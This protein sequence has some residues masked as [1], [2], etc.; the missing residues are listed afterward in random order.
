MSA[1]SPQELRAALAALLAARAGVAPSFVA[2]RAEAARGD[3]GLA[4]AV[5]QALVGGGAFI[6]EDPGARRVRLEEL[7][8]LPPLQELEDALDRRR[9]RPL[10]IEQRLRLA[11]LYALIQRDEKGAACYRELLGASALP[12]PMAI[13]VAEAAGRAGASALALAG[14]DRV[15]ETILT[16]D[17]TGEQVAGADLMREDPLG[18]GAL[19]ERARDIALTI[20]HAPRAVALARA[21]TALYERLGRRQEARESLAG[22]ARALRAAGRGKRARQVAERWRELA[23]DDGA[24]VSQARALAWLAGEAEADGAVRGAADLLGKAEAL[25]VAAGDPAGALD[26][27]RRRGAL[28]E[29]A[30]ALAEAGAALGRALALTEEAG[31]WPGADAAAHARAADD[32][33]LSLARLDLVG[34]RPGR[35]LAAAGEVRAARLADGDAAGAAA[36][37]A[38]VAEA[39]VLAGDLPGAMEVVGEVAP[40][41]AEHDLPAAR[42]RAAR[43]RA[44][45]AALDGR[46]GDA[47]LLLHDAAGDLRRAGDEAEAALCVLRRAEVLAAAGDLDGCR[48]ELDHALALAGGLPPRLELRLELL[49]ALLA[50]AEEADLLL[51]EVAERAPDEGDPW[52]RAAVAGA[53]ARRGERDGLEAAA[54]EVRA[55]RDDLPPTLRAGFARSPLVR[56]LGEAGVERVV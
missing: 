35:A 24:E 32:L 4:E 13:E 16:R 36:A 8:A 34:G 25:L 20:G 38:V 9:A 53:R 18:A 15:A 42:G 31:G 2:A 47:A 46:P 26:H 56:L 37:A 29:R 6:V 33:R 28:L 7:D 14:I 12:V 10:T 50:P 23:E 27:A 22:Q 52:V 44:E 49:R 54:A 39:L 43:A 40:V 5:V 21:A 11:R 48:R 41:L 51:D 3:A 19:L 1:T 55:V 30:G 17:P 45:V